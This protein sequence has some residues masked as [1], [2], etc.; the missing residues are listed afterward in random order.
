VHVRFVCAHMHGHVCEHMWAG[1]D[2]G[3]CKCAPHS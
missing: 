1:W 3:V 2:D